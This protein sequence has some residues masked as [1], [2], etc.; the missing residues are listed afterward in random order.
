MLLRNEEKRHSARAE[1]KCI[2]FQ[3]AERSNLEGIQNIIHLFANKFI[4][5]SDIN[6]KIVGLEVML[7]LIRS[8]HPFP[9]VLVALDVQIVSIIL[10]CLN[11][12]EPKIRCQAIRTVL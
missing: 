7:T 9:D 12:N 10:R 3:L 5:A 8:L 1:L 4:K 6:Q 11:N 2:A